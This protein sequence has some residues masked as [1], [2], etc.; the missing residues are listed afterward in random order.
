M[1]TGGRLA[2]GQ[3]Q[4]YAGQPARIV[5]SA[6]VSHCGAAASK[7]TAGYAPDGKGAK[8]RSVTSIL[9]NGTT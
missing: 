1:I 6:I 4:Q 3:K 8:A 5:D 2:E 7:I 9:R